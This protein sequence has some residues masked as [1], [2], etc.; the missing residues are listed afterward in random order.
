MLGTPPA[1]VRAIN[2]S[3]T[4]KTT[5]KILLLV[6]GA[7]FTA[8]AFAGLVGIATPAVFHDTD[9]AVSIFCAVG[10]LLIGATD[11]PRRQLVTESTPP[12]PMPKAD[13]VPYTRRSRAY[14]I[15]RNDRIAA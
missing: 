5:L 2:E 10:L 13:V 9:V 3:T 8:I 4:M 14:G 12:F 11:R 15:R 7:G 6:L 1:K